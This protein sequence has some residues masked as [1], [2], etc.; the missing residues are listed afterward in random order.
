MDAILREN[1]ARIDE[2]EAALQSYEPVHCPVKHRFTE[3]MY[4]REIFMPAGTLLTSKIHN[5]EHPYTISL[6]TA[7]VQID[8][9]S[10]IH[11]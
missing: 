1:D 6:G 11:I 3:G 10:L 5:T 4:I 2:L 9:L 7:A 8:G